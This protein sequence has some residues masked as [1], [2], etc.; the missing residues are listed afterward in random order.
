MLALLVIFGLLL[1]IFGLLLAIF[2]LLLGTL[3]SWDITTCLFM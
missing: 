3:A 1:A 2:G